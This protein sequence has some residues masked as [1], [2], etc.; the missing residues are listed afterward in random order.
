[1]LVVG[2]AALLVLFVAVV[3]IVWNPLGG[4]GTPAAVSQTQEAPTAA[5]QAQA[6]PTAVSQPA[7]GPSPALPGQVAYPP[8][9]TNYSNSNFVLA[10]A[11]QGDAL[12]AGG[13][14]GLV[15]W[16]VTDGTY[17]TLG[18][19]DGLASTRINDL[20]VDDEGLLW[21]ATD[22]G[23]NRYDGETFITYEEI[24]GL[25]AQWIEALFLDDSGGLW[26]GSQGGERGLN[27]YDGEG[28]GSPPVPPLPV[29]SWNVQALGGNEQVPLFVGLEDQGLALFDGETWTVLTNTDVLTVGQVAEGLL[30]DEALWLSSDAALARLDL[31]TGDAET[32]PQDGIQTMYQTAGGEIWFGGAGRVLRFDPGLGDWQEFEAGPDSIPNRQVTDI[33][34]DEAGLWF[35]TYGGGVIFYNGSRWETW[36][37]D[38]TL[39]GNWIEAIRQGRDGALW[40]SHPGTGLSRY[41]PAGNSWQVF[42]QPEGV[43]DWPSFPA[44]DSEGN[45]WT[46]GS[47]ELVR[48]DGQAWQRFTA[49]E[50]AEVEI[51]AIDIDPGDVQ[52]LV[53][54][55]G[56]MRH[57]PALGEW[58]TFTGADHPVLAEITSILAASD[59]NV[60]AGGEGGLVRY[61]GRTWSTPVA[62]GNPPQFVDDLAEAADGSLWFAADGR[63]GHLADDRWSYLVWPPDRWLNRVA[64]GPDGSVWVGYEGLGRYDPA[65]G[66]WQLFTP[67]DGLVH[68]IVHAIYV[69]PEGVVWVGTEGGVSRYVPPD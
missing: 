57:D 60:W 18:R 22:A 31:E 8:G 9:W 17:T 48:S 45:L 4:Q 6:T 50:L 19:E 5:G 2:G 33:V 66:D 24:D 64:V 13:D 7:A 35:G 1:L 56:L 52:W 47:G 36:A 27:Y 59:G 38:E 28:W 63:L 12:W 3:F 65:S 39:G 10:L 51:Y 30:T 21:I 58:T 53:T 11:R 54:D 55:H 44:I 40:F 68:Q 61:D 41:E 34:P 42:G 32:F 15:R 23:V 25:D 69:T 26:A 20:L 16:D 62:S 14:G 46:G 43:L 49:P 29:G 67:A 37:T